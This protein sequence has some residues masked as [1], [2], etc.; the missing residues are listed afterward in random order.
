MPLPSPKGG[1]NRKDFISECMSNGT[2]NKE[3]PDTK[4]RVAVCNAKW[5]E[6]QAIEIDFTEQIKSAVKEEINE[7]DEC[8]C[9]ECGCGKKEEAEAKKKGL[10][11]NIRDKKKSKDKK[12]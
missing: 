2:M 7:P 12:K 3:F 6:S 11:E 1:K 9:D 4:Q 10:W 8:G 5:K